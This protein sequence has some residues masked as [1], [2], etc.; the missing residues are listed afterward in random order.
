MILTME[1]TFECKN[2]HEL[3]KIAAELLIKLE[4]KTIVAVF[5]ALG[6]GKTTLIK[7]M[8]KK[9]GVS[10]PVSSPTFALMNEYT[11]GSQTVYH[12]DFYRI[13]SETEAYDIGYEDFFY[14][15]N[16]CFIEWPEK[17]K[18]LLPDDRAEI[19][20]AEVNGMR[21]IKLTL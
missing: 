5:G 11:T 13:K 6:A 10:D 16:V 8:C 18:N 15:G 3:D 4:D 2:L 19:H 12:F 17:I 7:S 14:S 21:Q 1:L 9:L 20:I